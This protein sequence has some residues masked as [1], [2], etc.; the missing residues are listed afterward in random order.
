MPELPE[1]EF[2]AR[3][4]RKWTL[5]RVVVGV[6]AM[7]GL[8]LRETSAAQLKAALVGSRITEVR[9]HGKQLFWALSEG[10]MLW[11]HLG[12]TGKWVRRSSEEAQRRWSR[13]ALVLDDGHTL[14]FVDPRRFGR[15]RL[16]QA[17]SASEDSA[18]TGTGPDALVA[19]R[20]AGR[21]MAIFGKSKQALKVALLN[22]KHLAGIGNIYA[23]EALFMAGIDPRA[24][25]RDVQPQGYERLSRCLLSALMDSLERESGD[26]IDYLNGGGTNPFLV[27]G[28]EGE[29]CPQCARS[30]VRI[31]QGGRSTFYCATCQD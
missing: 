7:D 25:G 11:V 23:A 29:P 2:C 27:Y 12:M 18:Q 19:C 17:H 26:E 10:G 24:L 22:Q 16:A 1:V 8:P 4:L 9:R 14:D 21:I 30:I 13:V 20:E 3:H 5:E 31:T 6:H 28:R 15:L